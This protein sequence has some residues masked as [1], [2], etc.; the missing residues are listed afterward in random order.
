VEGGGSTWPRG[1]LAIAIASAATLPACGGA[2]PRGAASPPASSPAPAE[3]DEQTAAPPPPAATVPPTSAQAPDE[4]PKAQSGGPLPPRKG[5]NVEASELDR[6][7]EDVFAATDCAS[8]CRALSSMQRA[9]EHL[10]ALGDGSDDGK[11]RC[12]EAKGKLSEAS[13]RVKA[14]CGSCP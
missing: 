1:L 9:T 5:K 3:A 4:S 6:A 14:S 11:R 13:A 8:M 2:A 12:S 10:C 7:R